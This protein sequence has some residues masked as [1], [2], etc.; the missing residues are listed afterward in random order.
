MAGF[1]PSPRTAIS[2]RT[3][4]DPSDPLPAS[5][6]VTSD[7]IAA[8]VALDLKACELILIK[9]APLPPGTDRRAAARLGLVDPV[10]PAFSRG[11]PRVTYRN[12]R[13]P[14]E[15]PEPLP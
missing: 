12:L 7:T 15:P 14:D 10:F 8:R 2:L 5:W 9:S 6:D 4:L 11:L 3:T 13:G 1:P